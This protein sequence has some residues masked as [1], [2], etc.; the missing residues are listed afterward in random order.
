VV[1]LLLVGLVFSL[2]VIAGALVVVCVIAYREV[3]AVAALT[4]AA[5]RLRIAI[6]DLERRISDIAVVAPAPAP[7][8]RPTLKRKKAPAAE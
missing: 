4:A 6:E 8:Q 1:E 5:V 3:D 7:E 2:L